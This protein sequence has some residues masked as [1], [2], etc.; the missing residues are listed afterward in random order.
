M[1]DACVENH[2][3]ERAPRSD[4]RYLAFVDPC[5]GTADAMTLA[6]AHYDD[7]QVVLD[8]LVERRPPFSPEAVVEN[9]AAWLGRYRVPTVIGEGPELLP[10]VRPCRP[11][12]AHPPAQEPPRQRCLPG[13][14]RHCRG[15]GPAGRS[16][17]GALG[18]RC[19]WRCTLWPVGASLGVSRGSRSHTGRHAASRWGSPRLPGPS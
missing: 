14:A 19:P 7:R 5:G 9:F 8:A 12:R 2:C 6:I 15:R 10:A 17:I 18:F 13:T 4:V 11:D 3:R 1:I 16:L